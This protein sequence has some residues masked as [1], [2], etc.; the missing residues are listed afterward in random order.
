MTHMNPIAI[1]GIGCRFPGGA[2]GPEAFWR[3]LCDGVDAIGEVPAD[4]W[5]LDAYYD[6]VPGR[7]GKSI[8]RWG[9][10]VDS[11]DQFDAGFFGISP[12]EAAFVD[13]QQR[14][15][16]RAAWEALEDGGETPD[17]VGGSPVGVFI[18]IATNDYSWLQATPTDNSGVDI[19]TAT[20]GV[21]S[22]A[23]NRISYCLNLRGPSIAV[24]TA[25]SSSLVA[26]HLACKSLLNGE[27]SLALAGGVNALIMPMPFI[28]FSRSSMLSPD[29][30]CKAFDARA[31]GFV[32]A[33]GA[34]VIALKPLAA[35][36]ADGGP[37]YAVILGTAVNQDGRT[38]GITVPSPEA[39]AAL[40]RET[41]R[42]AGV[43]PGQVQ[44]VE[45][46][47][48]GT[49][50]GDPIEAEALGA[51]LGAGRGAATPCVIGSV[52]TNIGHLEAGAGIAGL[53][54]VALSLHHGQIPPNLHFETPNPRIDFEKLRIRVAQKM[55]K[56]R[57]GGEP[58]VAGVNSFGFGGTNAHAILQAA[59]SSAGR[60][61]QAAEAN[62][63]HLLTL[64]ARSTESLRG[65]AEKYRAFLGP[66]G[67][68]RGTSLSD[69][70]FSAG[71][72]R[73]HHAR[74][75]AVAGTTREDLIEKLGAFLA[76][77]ARPGVS[78]GQPVAG[79][80]P[81]F[82]FSGQG[83]QWWAMGREL[84]NEEHGFREKIAE[85]D[86]LLRE[87]GGWSLIEELSR[88]ESRSRLQQTE[89]AQP[90]IFALQVAL[91]TLWQ[92]WGIRP[93]AAVGHSVGEVAAAHIAGVLTLREAARVI[94]HRGRC[95][96]KA[97]ERGRML[98]AGLS[99]AQ[100][101]ETIE[102]YADRISI[103]A[104]N[105]P[106]SVALSGDGEALEAIAG[107]L[108]ARGIFCRFLQVNYAFHSQQMDPVRDELLRSLGRVEVRPA[109]LCLMSTVTGALA[110]AAEFGGDYWWL[111]VRQPV[112]FATAIAVLLERGH[113]TFLELSAHPAL[114]GSILECMT[115]GGTRGTVL[116]SLRR[117]EPERVTMLGSL[118]M[119]HV[120]GCPV[121]WSSLYPSSGAIRL[122]TYAWQ[123]ERYWNEAEAWREARLS[124]V[125][126]PLLAQSLK[127]ASPTWQTLLEPD[128][129]PYLKDHLVQGQVVFPAAGYVEMAL[130]A[131]RALFGPTAS[132]LEDVDFQR[133]LFLPEG[134]EPVRLEFGCDPREGGFT[135]AGATGG[136]E[137]TWTVH[138]V[139][140]LRRDSGTRTG[141]VTALDQVRQRCDEEVAPA[142]IYQMYRD[143]GLGFGPSFC[144]IE[145]AR[146]RD[147]EAIGRVRLAPGLEA[148]SEK[149]QVHP[150]LLDAC[151]Q[152]LP[153]A[154]PA[155]EV[156]GRPPLYLPVQVER[157]RWFEKPGR[158]AWGHAVLVQHGGRS[159]VGDVRVLDEEGRVLLEINGY[160]CQAV[161]GA[162]GG[163]GAGLDECLYALDWRPR[164]LGRVVRSGAFL[165]PVSRILERTR[166]LG[167]PARQRRGGQPEMQQL[168]AGL[169]GICRAYFIAALD[170][171]GC[172]L[173]RGASLG[174]GDLAERLGVAMAHRQA[175]R[176]FL[177]LLQRDGLVVRA[178]DRLMVRGDIG[179]PGPE[180]LA[181]RI[182][183]RFPGALPELMLV[184]LCGRELAGVL[185]G[186]VNPPR[187]ISAEGAMP[188]A[189]HFYQDSYSCRGCNRAMAEAVAAAIE[190]RP[191]GRIVRVLE[192]GAGTGGTTAH[193]LPR[194]P[195]KRTEYVFTDRDE[196]VFAVA[197]Q[198]FFDYPFVRYQAMDIDKPPAEQGFEEHS[199]DLVMVANV[200]HAARD[201]RQ[202]LRH[203]R[204]LLAPEGLLLLQEFLRP[205][206][207][208]D[209]ALGLAEGW[210]RARDGE[211]RGC[212]TPPDGARWQERLIGEGFTDV[213]AIPDQEGVQGARQLMLMARGPMAPATP[214]SKESP[215]VAPKERTG[216]WLIFADRS[217]LAQGVAGAL[218][219]RG[220]SAVTVYA[221]PEFGRR[222]SGGF[223]VRP[224]SPDDVRLLLRE[225]VGRD[226]PRLAGV[227]HLWNLDAQPPGE[228]SGE[229]LTE[230]EIA[231]C[232]S[233]VHLLQALG[234]EAA[235][236]RPDLWLITRG[237][238][239]VETGDPVH[240][241]QAPLWGLGR[242]IT[243]EL[244]RFRCRMID[245][246]PVPAEDEV[247]TLMVELCA[248]D[249]EGEVAHRGSTRYVQRMVRTTLEK[250]V[251]PAGTPDGETGFRLECVTP[252][253]LDQLAFRSRPRRA[254]ARDEVEVEV[255]AAALN[256]RDVMKAL[257]IYPTENDEDLLLGDE[258]A[259][260]I[261]AVGPGVGRWREGDEVVVVAP[262]CF[263]SH[264]TVPSGRVVR[265][266]ERLGFDEAATIPVAYL[267]AWY[268]LHHLGRIRAGER[269]L[270]Q[271]ATGGVGLAAVQIAQLAGA[272][273][274]ATAGSPQ[275][276]EFLHGLG[277]AHVMDS[278]SLAFADEVREITRGRGVD[279]VLNSLA[280][281]AI[282]KGIS[283]LAPGGRFLE[284]GKRDIYQNAKV[285]LRPFRHNISLFV[286]DL[287][288]VIRDDP[289]LIAGLLEQILSLF[290]EERLHPLPLRMFGAAQVGQAFRYMSQARHIGK[291]VLSMVPDGVT[292]VTPP[293]G[294][295][296]HFEANATYLITGGLGGFGLALA[297]WMLRGGARHLVLAGRGG[298]S[299][300]V[301]RR[302]VEGLRRG[303]GEVVVAQADVTRPSDV[304]Q[305]F[306][307]IAR[308][309]PPLRGIVHAAMVMDDCTIEQQTADRFHRVMAPKTVGSWNLHARS[310]DLPLDFFILFSSFSSMAGNPGQCSYAAANCFMDALA[311]HRRARGLPALVVNWGPLGEVGYIARH[312]DLEA[313]LRVQGLSP[314]DPGEA[315]AMLGSLLGAGTAQAGVVRI[316]W[317]RVASYMSGVAASPRYEEVRGSASAGDSVDGGLAGVSIL[318]LPESERLA[319]V[320]EALKE[321]VAKVLRTSAAKLDI[322]RPLNTLGF[323][324]LMSV[325]L[326][327]R[328]E[329]HFRVVLPPGKITAAATAANLAGDLLGLMGNSP[330]SKAVTIAV[331]V[332]SGATPIQDLAPAVPLAEPPVKILVAP[333][334]EVERVAQAAAE[335]FAS[336]R[337]TGSRWGRARL[338]VQFY[339]EWLLLRAGI[340]YLRRGDYPQACRRM[341][342][343]ARWA[344]T[345]L[346]SD[347]RWAQQ[348]LKLVFGPNL[349]ESQRQRLATLAFENHFISYLEGLRQ[350]DV[351][352]E[353]HQAE[354]LLDARSAGR[355]VILCGVHL[356]SWEP[357]LS[358]GSREG[359]PIAALYRRAFNPLSDRVFQA[360][361]ASYDV[362]WILSSNVGAAFEALRSGKI[363]GLM[364]DLNVTTGGTVADFLGVPA[365]CPSGPARLALMQGAPIVPGVA[366]RSGSGKLDVHFEPAIVPP[367]N[368]DSEEQVR[369]LTRRIN[370]AF[371]PWILE[372]AEQYNWLHPRWRCRPDGREWT[373]GMGE[374]VLRKERT[375]PFLA[376]PERV[377]RLIEP[378]P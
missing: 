46:H 246:A 345:V 185:R 119:L 65:L 39:Q 167:E 72:R 347:W 177:D 48:T 137:R 234:Q 110:T 64:S 325:E 308:Q 9:G 309:M 315:T 37:I 133:A 42:A 52:K 197:E 265:M 353:F 264:I 312:A 335:V 171:L 323:D 268:A 297:E 180:S 143:A 280:G 329:G 95:M 124:P 144:G 195:R 105:G 304:S 3:L 104:L 287:A 209:L 116:P 23:A 94:F 60:T 350:A 292:A 226:G 196:Q 184:D 198:K 216:T 317:Q 6:P 293:D 239:A 298:A 18:G 235:N 346:R 245:L 129:L 164:S 27:C 51:A 232:H 377:R 191:E 374:G 192:I 205:T 313:A 361:R 296:Q 80:G 249:G 307:M 40:V 96:E 303:G 263:S 168:D 78:E 337:P 333:P 130:G 74:R 201:V 357:G 111:N 139:G 314:I 213:S 208:G 163:V 183:E 112:L 126:H 282:A 174:G 218:A 142:E 222:E 7:K 38:N 153:L 210:W 89:I 165:A 243:N 162:R 373:T 128:A 87:F 158:V 91:A 31:N 281:E 328:I 277:V 115:K 123:L 229:G 253:A 372:Y 320:T 224:E 334:P 56:Y 190:R 76:G 12:R 2:D 288:Q 41:C 166:P 179:R 77:E 156:G 269:V 200:L 34:G 14:L 275:K 274:F 146:R 378:A 319:A 220:E 43:V 342:L 273:V 131:A 194:L 344:R 301:A 71:K 62:G 284:I 326:V 219:A 21:A 212:D 254:P 318:D 15:L 367:A 236:E 155:G 262:G 70:C 175:F 310:A 289:S 178:D 276:R 107:T 169:D 10:F 240:V 11:I 186:T 35:A 17:A 92:E 170:R 127:A 83:P 354:R 45:T 150:T 258:C 58:A 176:C 271:A 340:A 50:V 294:R 343:L 295:A 225:V 53:I 306:D 49:A 285:G 67:A 29:G 99:W 215:A 19:W 160:R 352:F 324:S 233:V 172:N 257:G 260:R 24:D 356:G 90:A 255:R 59:P 157:V 365:R 348:N 88:D 118:G 231:C 363:L 193:I 82:V 369:G 101:Q 321:Q 299:T 173:E 122:P 63:A 69:A 278:R 211:G 132:V 109:E 125:A 366:I 26:V 341:R 338:Q 332:S 266:P 102:P 331:P 86:A 371:E 267:T 140:R 214:E 16:L 79:P 97:P 349:T 61:L 330:A 114:A 230:S 113:H 149:Y 108:E 134:E 339:L 290:A 1:T 73:V 182:L 355:G 248:G 375:A 135:I 187:L 75:L 227:V 207:M 228:T 189:E 154:I 117:K 242:V 237:A 68:G 4:R 100:A 161:A 311:H 28:S 359:L 322:Q 238:Q 247:G 223:E 203:I 20:G 47:G 44:Y 360:I 370:A 376:V 250:R 181:R 30:R 98:A 25:C 152:L 136:A 206:W 327:N 251:V 55:E 147:G 291:I 120:L 84:L 85:C 351:T 305:L 302:A 362:E 199:F 138:A 256:F 252:G 8:A 81:V 106:N 159:F 13:P 283:C 148:E 259:G 202:A 66:S 36:V 300:E 145:M 368:E 261:S 22:I 244:T 270:I 54:K 103:A 358:L 316:E 151:F 286:I 141:A 5:N 204:E 93:A 221:G 33:E 188:F 57:A 32:R 121:N 241:A 336:P 272:E 217:G 364:T 279:L